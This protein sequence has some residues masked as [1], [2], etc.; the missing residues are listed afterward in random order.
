MHKP[1]LASLGF[2]LLFSFAFGQDSDFYR[3]WGEISQS[4]IRMEQYDK[5]PE[6]E[7]LILHDI[8]ESA[9]FWKNNTYYVRFTRRRRIKILKESGLRFATVIMNYYTQGLSSKEKI[10]SIEANTYNF[11]AGELVKTPLDTL[12]VYE[13]QINERLGSKRFAM[14]K[15]KIGSIIEY[16]YVLESP[17]V[18]KLPAW[19][20]QDRIPTLFSSYSVRFIPIYSYAFISQGIEKFDYEGTSADDKKR[21]L[22]L[23]SF[24]D[25]IKTYEM[26]EVPAFK[27][28]AFISTLNDYIMKIDFQLASI[29]YV[30]GGVEKTI[31]SWP[32]LSK[33]LRKHERFG[34]FVG[35]ARSSSKSFFTRELN[36]KH[37]GQ[38]QVAKSIIQLVKERYTWNGSMDKFATQSVKSFETTQRGNI[39]DINLYLAGMLQAAGIKAHPV[40]LST[41]DHGKIKANYP[42]GHFFNYVIVLID[43]GDKF[44]LAD[45]SERFLPYNR[46]PARAINHK[47]L[48]IEKGTSKWVDLARN[49]IAQDKKILRFEIDP[50]S[51]TA[52]TSLVIQSREF[53]AYEYRSTFNNEE[54]KL[55]EF[56]EGNGFTTCEEISTTN[57]DEVEASYIIQVKGKTDL[58]A[59]GNEVIVYPF[60]GFPMS[61]NKLTQKERAY[62][63]DFITSSQ[64]AFNSVCNIPQGYDLQSGFE[65]FHLEDDLVKI[66]LTLTRYDAGIELEGG[67]TFKKAVYPPQDYIQLKEHIDTIIKVFGQALVFKAAKSSG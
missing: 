26:H 4:Q 32:E 11:E 54:A 34:R 5:D 9:F 6:A 17:F 64:Q 40:I 49:G 66:D 47:G 10:V 59:Y 67:Y 39:A 18:F 25:L 62:P 13:V 2:A 3:Q 19:H 36:I 63:V 35:K 53:K 20:F 30:G 27:D 33:T 24:S 21:F 7:A 12:Q 60:L 14:P 50:T 48:I 43:L 44:Y 45:A 23:S 1:I 42:F 51:Q 15:V 29:N 46:I 16:R 57:F 55:C 28:E 8:G 52:Q 61:T 56:F 31:S 37:A 22:G 41:R 58:G 65:D 38:T